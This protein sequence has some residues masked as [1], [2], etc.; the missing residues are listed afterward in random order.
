MY[1]AAQGKAC[2]DGSGAIIRFAGSNVVFAPSLSWIIL[3][4]LVPSWPL[5][6]HAQAVPAEGTETVLSELSV[7]GS[8]ERAGGPVVGYRAARSGTATRTDTAL[9]DTPQ[10]IQVVPREVLVDQQD[11]RLTDALTNVSNVQ[12]GGTIQGRSDTYI[13]RGF[14]TQTYAVDGLVLNPANAFQ[15]T[16]R[17]LA[18]VERVEVLKGPA[19]VLYGQGDPGGLINIVT[20]QPTLTPSADVTVQGGSFGFRRVQGSV[21]GAIPSVEGL[22]A[23]FS[24]AT[25]DEATF[26]DFGGPENSRHYFAPALVWTPDPS[27]RVFLNAE[28]TRQHSQYDEG[29]IAFRGRVPLDNVRRFYGEPWSR[30]YGEANAIALLAE[31]DVNESLTLRQA[32]NGQWG[33]FN[34]LATRATGVNAAGTTVARRLTEGDSL[35]HSIDSRTEAVGRFVDPFGFRHTALAGFE[36]VDG[37]RHPYTTQGTATSVSFLNPIRGSVPQVG[38]LALQSDLRQ[39]LSLFG[40]YMQDQIEFFPGLQLV[41]GV[42]FDTADQLYFQRTPTTRTIPPEQNLTGVSPRVGI[43]WRPVEP[44]TLYGSYTTSFVPQSA[45]IL[46]VASPPPETGEQVEVGARFDLIPDQLTVSAAAFRIL[47]ANV[48]ASDPVNTGFSIITGE[49]RSQGFEGDIAGEILP[50]WKIIGGI[51][52]LD[53]EVT[54]DRFIPVGNRLPAAPVFSTSVWSTYQF[55]GGP[56]R[57]FGFGG[58]ITYVG[59]RFGD[60]TNTYKVGAYARLDAALFYEIDPTWRLAVNGRNLTDR[61]YIEQPFNPF[62]NLPGAP[63]TVLASLTARY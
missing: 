22:A 36:I 29:L 7:T 1:G 13:L 11:V 33:T 8:G 63:L 38:T 19:S 52:Y 41:L 49:Q 4:L 6:A 51:G 56:L 5:G 42:R 12:P 27:T 16:Q 31:H 28:F 37:Y 20:R 9:R 57:G 14:R 10:S 18:N 39:K 30:Y 17:D 34:L 54:K 60:I 50:G 24:F 2:L 43:V 25:Q 15:P 3:A 55:Q 48:A 35:Y 45:N 44:L 46:N 59:E 62:N 58:G 26:R 47:R 32:I 40:V 61:R 23:R 53:A 21:S